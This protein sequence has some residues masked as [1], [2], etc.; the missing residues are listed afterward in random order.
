MSFV[1]PSKYGADLPQ[2]KDP[3]VT[4][5]EV[6]SKI[7]AVVAF[8]GSSCNLFTSFPVIDIYFHFEEVFDCF[9]FDQARIYLNFEANGGYWCNLYLDLTS[10]N[11]N[12]ISCPHIPLLEKFVI[13]A[14]EIFTDDL[15][16]ALIMLC[17]SI[18]N[19]LGRSE[20]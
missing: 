19:Y 4:I 10:V 6:P 5:Q 15:A 1:M 12:F 16:L 8:P 13:K 18:G 3:S 7:I 2:A 9:V 14:D 11:I 17:D 20:F